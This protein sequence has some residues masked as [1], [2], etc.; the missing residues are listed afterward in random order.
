M[1]NRKYKSNF[2]NPTSI[3]NY[4]KF[5][6]SLDKNSNKQEKPRE[7][8]NK[9]INEKIDEKKQGEEVKNKSNLDIMKKKMEEIIKS[10]EDSLVENNLNL[11]LTSGI[12]YSDKFL[13]KY[14]TNPNL[15]QE[16]KDT[17][18]KERFKEKNKEKW[19]KDTW[20]TDTRDK[21]IFAK[22][23]IIVNI[24]ADIKGI[25]DIIQL[26]ETYPLEKHLKYNINMEMLHKIKAPLKE[27][28]AMIGIKNLKSNLLDQILYFSQQLHLNKNNNGEYMHTVIYG[29]PGTGKTEI[30]KIMGKIYGNIGVLNKGVFKKVTRSDLIAGYLGQTAIKTKD[31]IKECLGGVLFIDEAYSLGNN[32]KRDSFSK[33]CI[34]TLCEALSDHKDDLMVIIAGYEEELKDCFF[35]YNQGLDS[36]FTWRF[37]TDEYKGVDLCEIFLKKL[38]DIGWTT[39]IGK[40]TLTEWFE[41]NILYFAFY[42]RDIETLLAKIKIAHS[43]RVFCK[44]ENEKKSI[45]PMD[46]EK[47]LAMFLSNDNVKNRKESHLRKEMLQSIYI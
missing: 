43:K 34:D 20:N 42:G 40:T 6:I 16:R 25:Q 24:Q 23:Q 32:E 14:Q 45:S 8:E 11:N 38:D 18:D 35:N 12:T 31:V 46:L 3:D 47:G 21:E 29:P 37:K 30:A 1:L 28:D 9:P 33:E 2:N 22:D 26:T 7:K 36:R 19:D 5:L 44:P 39:T 41:K 27:L 13:N 17:T 4:N 15:Y 10:I